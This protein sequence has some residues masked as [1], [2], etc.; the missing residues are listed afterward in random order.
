M[1]RRAAVIFFL[2]VLAVAGA[3]PAEAQAPNPSFNLVNK[4]DVPI[5]DL[6]ATP[7]GMENWG[8]SRIEGHPIAPG[9]SFA[10][11]L[12]ADGNCRYDIRVTFANGRTEDRRGVDTCAVSDVIFGT[13]GAAVAAAQPAPAAAQQ[14]SLRLINHGKSAITEV[15]ATPSSAG[16]VGDNLLTG[17]ATLAPQASQLFQM[18]PGAGC[19]YDLRVV[20]ADKASRE[21]KGADLCRITDLPVQ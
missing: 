19:S 4:S 11:R 2:P 7:A 17:G 14:A 18:P 21:K 12:R 13:P 20:F 6:F 16:K 15:Y 10:V 9:G 5:R 8:R 1:L 3:A